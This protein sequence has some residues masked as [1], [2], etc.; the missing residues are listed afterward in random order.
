MTLVLLSCGVTTV[1]LG[2]ALAAEVSGPTAAADHRQPA[3]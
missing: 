3:G 2:H 1:V